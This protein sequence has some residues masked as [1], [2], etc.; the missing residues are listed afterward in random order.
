MLTLHLTLNNQQVAVRVDGK[1]SHAFSFLDL[2]QTEQEWEDFVKNPRP[3]G[4]KLFQALFRDGS[5]ARKAFDELS[6]QDERTIVLVLESSALDGVAWE[7]AY[8]EAKEEYVVEDC[9]FMRALPESERPANGRLKNEVERVPLLFIPANPLTLDEH[10]KPNPQL[11]LDA[12]WNEMKR[13]IEKSGAPFDVWK[14]LPATPEKLQEVMA[15]FQK[16]LLVHFTGHGAA[17]KEGALLLFEEENGAPNPLD[18]REFI[19]QVKDRAWIVFLSACQSAVAQRS[20]F[21]NL[22]RELARA[23]VPFALGMQFN[24]PDKYDEIISAQFYNYLAQGHSVL[25]ATLQAR[26]ALKRAAKKDALEFYIGLIALYAAHPEETGKLTWRGSGAQIVPTFRAA[27]VSDLPA[28]D[29]GLIGRQRE[30]MEIGTRLFNQKERVITLHG[31]GGIGKTALLREALLRFAPSFDLTLALA[32]DP[33]PSLERILG[34]LEPALNLPAPC[35][36][37]TQKRA[38]IVRNAL[39]SKRALLGLDNFEAL[40]HALNEAGSENEATAIRLHEFFSSLCAGGVAL[41][42]TSR[43]DTELPGETLLELYGLEDSAGGD[44]F[45]ANVGD[46]RDSLTLEQA[47]QISAAVAGH[48]LALGLLGG[49][50]KKHADLSPAEF[51]QKINAFLLETKN[52]WTKTKRHAS[53]EACFAFSL[54]NLPDTEEGEALRTGLSRLSV[55]VAYFAAYMV[56][57]TLAGKWP[58]NEGQDKAQQDTAQ[59]MVHALWERGLLERLTLPLEH[60]NFHLYRLHPALNPFA[61]ERVVPEDLPAMRETH[62]RAMRQLASRSYPASEGGGIYGSSFLSTMAH[63]A[64]P[65]MRKAAQLKQDKETSIL[66]YHLAFLNTHF[67]DLDGAMKLYQQSLEIKEGLG[68]QQGKSA[69]LHAVAGIYVTRGDLDGAMKLYQQALAIDEGLGDQQGKS[70]TL[71]MLGQLLVARKDYPRAIFA[72]VESLQ[73]LSSIGARPDA[74]KV[75]EILVGIRQKIGAE[76][77]DIAWKQVTDSPL[78][79]WLSQQAEE[80]QSMTVEQFIAEAIQSAREKRPAAQQYFQAAQKMATDANAPAEL[81]ALGNVLQK[82][83]IGDTNANLSSLPAALAEIVKKALT[84]VH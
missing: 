27:D 57:P 4:L 49:V 41:C 59:N 56:A 83:M 54:D 51:L 1:E 29:S 34:R 35:S 43:K 5:A 22:A 47:C 81:Q 39:T 18:G 40:I 30:L 11:N 2:G 6:R 10:G 36:N 66:L 9:A 65:D 60:E 17:A 71:A 79:D 64:L 3:Y 45:R 7:Y 42:V 70:A 72:L 58:E 67:G 53:L 68:D 26:R 37:D 73:T 52:Q 33:L 28:P 74:Q 25:Q 78:P 16:G 14:M 20:E 62:F 44:L 24:L 75:A 77:F 48:P 55:F 15:H 21:S 61:A 31:A 8:N 63:V 84:T 19:R 13:L 69:T 80:Q 46:R 23:G 32:L 12:E 82:I 38:A 76:T 50:Y